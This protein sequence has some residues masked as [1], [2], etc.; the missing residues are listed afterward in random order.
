MIVFSR[1]KVFRVG[2]PTYGGERSYFAN[3]ADA[4]TVASGAGEWGSDETVSEV[5]IEIRIYENM[6]D[7]K[8]AQLDDLRKQALDKLTDAEKQALG[9]V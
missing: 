2:G 8:D 6:L 5:D 1:K 7:Y 4:F 9:L 3:Q